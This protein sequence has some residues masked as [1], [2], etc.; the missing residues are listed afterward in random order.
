M[1]R[2]RHPPNRRPRQEPFDERDYFEVD[3]RL[4]DPAYMS[5][6]PAEDLTWLLSVRHRRRAFRMVAVGFVVLIFAILPLALLFVR[7]LPPVMVNAEV[8]SAT[9]V[10]LL[11]FGLLIA[12]WR[13]ANLTAQILLESRDARRSQSEP[14]IAAYMSPTLSKNT[15]AGT[16]GDYVAE[17]VVYNTGQC[18][19]FV[20]ALHFDHYPYLNDAGEPNRGGMASSL[21][22]TDE[23]IFPAGHVIRT[24]WHC[25]VQEVHA[26]LADQEPKMPFVT[27]RLR[28][29]D[30]EARVCSLTQDYGLLMSEKRDSG[31]LALRHEFVSTPAGYRT[32]RTDKFPGIWPFG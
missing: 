7:T 24:S 29:R 17:V 10:I 4:V 12:T 3:G 30:A 18:P 25:S 5:S 23:Q 16:V 14:R 20:P 22:L 1:K 31:S 6:L 26:Y 8:Y 2:F 27:L 15:K 11:T 28:F 13:Y 19:A 21:G 32:R 9:A